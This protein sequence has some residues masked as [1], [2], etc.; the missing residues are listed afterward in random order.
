MCSPTDF[1]TLSPID[2]DTRSPIDFAA[3]SL[4][5][6]VDT[7]G[8]DHATSRD[9]GRSQLLASGPAGPEW[10]GIQGILTRSSHP[11]NVFICD[12]L[13]LELG[14]NSHQLACL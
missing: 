4:P 13:S 8:L 11:W 7:M 1:D 12:L 6:S 10:K 5:L 14:S 3:S 2:F 9:H